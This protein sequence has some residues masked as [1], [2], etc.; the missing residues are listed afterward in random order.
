MKKK[1]KFWKQKRKI[2][3]NW[4]IEWRKFNEILK[5]EK[6]PKKNIRKLVK[7]KKMFG[8]RNF[9]LK[10]NRNVCIS[11]HLQCINL[12]SICATAYL[13]RQTHTH[14]DC[15]SCS[16]LGNRVMDLCIVYCC[17]VWY[18]SVGGGRKCAHDNGD[19]MGGTPRLWHSNRQ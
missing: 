18:C 12:R 5:N 14:V 1:L 16:V 8:F 19:L 7:R 6:N 13:I 10:I 15:C 9:S 2:E 11:L 4:E 17:S 3:V